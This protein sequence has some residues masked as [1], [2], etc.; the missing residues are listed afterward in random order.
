[1]ENLHLSVI[2]AEAGIHW[3]QAL[4]D[5]RFRGS[6]SLYA[7]VDTLQRGEGI[8]GRPGD[9]FASGSQSP[10]IVWHR[11]CQLTCQ[12]EHRTPPCFKIAYVSLSARRVMNLGLMM[13]SMSG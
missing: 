10:A 3:H 4:R 7:F 6:D 8:H 11:I 2:P 13:V 9:C 1:M 12:V 5:S